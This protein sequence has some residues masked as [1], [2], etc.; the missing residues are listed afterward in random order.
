MEQ[1]AGTSLKTRLYLLVLAAFIPVAVMIFF[2]AEEQKALETEAVLN[3][4]LLLARAAANEENQQLDSTRNL[5]TA[6]ADAFLMAEGQE[7]RLSG[8][9]ANLLREAKGY[10]ALGIVDLNHTQ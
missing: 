7:D 8:L 1:F 5:L 10:S 3:K 4:A 2:I 9:F 6:I